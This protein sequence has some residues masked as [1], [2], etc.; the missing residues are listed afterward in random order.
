MELDITE[1]VWS[2]EQRNQY[3]GVVI[4]QTKFNVDGTAQFRVRLVRDDGTDEWREW[5]KVWTWRRSGSHVQFGQLTGAG[6]YVRYEGVISGFTITG[7]GQD[8][9]GIRYTFQL[10]YGEPMRDPRQ[11]NPKESRPYHPSIGHYPSEHNPCIVLGCGCDDWLGGPSTHCDC[12]HR[13][14][15]HAGMED[16]D[17]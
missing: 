5:V 9:Q 10:R 6:V 3:G 15:Q 4:F 11:F 13:R 2:G 14:S 8:D 1:G 17:Y 12:G 7:A 16:D